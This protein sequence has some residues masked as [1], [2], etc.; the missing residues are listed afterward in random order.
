V[1]EELGY[2]LDDPRPIAREAPYTY[3]LPSKEELAALL[4]GDLVK[5]IFR[6]DK[7]GEKWGAE[8]MWVTVERVDGDRLEGRLENDPDDMPCLSL[9]ARVRFDRFHVVD[10]LWAEDRVTPPPEPPQNREYWERCMVDAGVLTGELW[11][12]YLYRERPDGAGVDDEFPDSGW[13]IRGWREGFSDEE[14]DDQQIEYI[15]LGKVLNEDDSWLHLIDEPVG[16][17]FIR[18]SKEEPFEPSD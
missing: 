16:S 9:G 4:P 18:R 11:I 7:P 14:A 8:R 5:L 6:P 2:T 15:A 12:Y 3:F 13:R 1:S 17:A 10:I